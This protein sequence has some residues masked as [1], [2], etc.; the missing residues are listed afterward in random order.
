MEKRTQA[1]RKSYRPETLQHYGKN[2]LTQ[3]FSCEISENFKST[4]FEE[5]L[6]TFASFSNKMMLRWY[7]LDEAHFFFTWY[8]FNECTYLVKVSFKKGNS[9]LQEC[10]SS[11][12]RCS[13]RK[14]VLRNFTKFTG[15]HLCQSLFFNKVAGRRPATLLK[16]RPWHSC[17]KKRLWHSCFPV[18]FVKFLGTPFSQNTS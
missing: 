16:E 14:G 1:L 5:H 11:N 3:V 10:R 9:H 8:H 6:C 13:V 7:N 2:T 4:Y 12:H 17:L 18:I 15:K